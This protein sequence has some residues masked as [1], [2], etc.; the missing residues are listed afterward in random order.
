MAEA[1]GG[2]SPGDEALLAPFAERLSRTRSL[3]PG[4][5]TLHFPDGRSA[6]LECSPSGA[7]IVQG[8]SSG[9]EQPLLEVRG[10]AERIRAIVD[11]EKDAVRE[12]LAGGLRLRGDLSYLSD[13]GLELGFLSRA[14]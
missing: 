4:T 12:F 1:S 14:L 13:L 2:S 3:R 5:I 11:G 8:A 10:D 6:H 7:R 9:A